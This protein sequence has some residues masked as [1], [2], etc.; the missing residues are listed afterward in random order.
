MIN[1][2]NMNKKLYKSL[3]AGIKLLSFDISTE[4]NATTIQ[5]TYYIL[6]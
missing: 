1:A 2:E 6:Q 5:L 3:T 4:K